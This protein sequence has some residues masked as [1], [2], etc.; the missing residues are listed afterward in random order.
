MTR[1]STSGAILLVAI[2][3]LGVATLLGFNFYSS[4][5]EQGYLLVYHSIGTFIGGAILIGVATYFALR[6]EPMES[7]SSVQSRWRINV[8]SRRGGTYIIAMIFI[9]VLLNILTVQTTSSFSTFIIV[10][11]VVSATLIWLGGFVSS[12][13]PQAFQQPS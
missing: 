2:I 4:F 8:W 3:V 7:P 1:A 5:G 11:Q 12:Q 9:G 6:Y 10:L 13:L